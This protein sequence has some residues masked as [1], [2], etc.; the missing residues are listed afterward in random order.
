[1]NNILK[2]KTGSS[3]QAAMCGFRESDGGNNKK[4]S[5]KLSAEHFKA[6]RSAARA[7]RSSHSFVTDYYHQR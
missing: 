5:I 4:R 2:Q 6:C 3:I 1:M 7:G